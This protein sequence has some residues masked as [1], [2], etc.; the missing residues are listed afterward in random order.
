MAKADGVPGAD[1]SRGRCVS[2]GFLATHG[3]HDATLHEVGLTGRET[4]RI[5]G[6]G[7]HCFRQAAPLLQEIRDATVEPNGRRIQTEEVIV[8]VLRRDRNCSKWCLYE[9]GQ[10]AE[11]HLERLQMI[12]LE[13]E[14]K[15]HDL[16]LAAMERD[17][18]QSAEKI[19]A[20]SLEIA[21][22]VKGFTTK[23]TYA[24]F[25]VAIAILIFTALTYFGIK[26]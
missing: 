19:Q 15:A 2:C 26:P 11:K 24:A 10:S 16:R 23:W 21:K 4:G 3:I 17:S 20:D 13:E 14:R 22:A 25:A 5:G 9:S 12:Q 8:S 6:S 7:L 18:R 1:E